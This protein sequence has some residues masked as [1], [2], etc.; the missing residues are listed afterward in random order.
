MTVGDID[1]DGDLD[2][3]SANI[4]AP[5]TVLRNES[6]RLGEWLIVDAPGA[7]RRC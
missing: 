7:W 3:V 1:N 2:L 4:D 5:P 6:N